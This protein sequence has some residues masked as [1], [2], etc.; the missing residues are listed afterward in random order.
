LE[1]APQETD[2]I[3]HYE[4][5]PGYG[6]DRLVLLVRD[7]QCVFAFWEVTDHGWA[8]AARRLPSTGETPRLTLRVHDLTSPAAAPGGEATGWGPGAWVDLVV[9]GADRWYLHLPQ[10]GRTVA[11]E[12]GAG[13]ATAFVPIARSPAVTTPPGTVAEW[14]EG[15]WITAAVACQFLAR[16]PGAT[17]P[18]RWSPQ[19]PPG[20]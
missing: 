5:P 10:P 6:V 13:T 11:A 1:S 16:G 4:V 2:A 9:A 14:A 12:I 17:S 8:A 20:V 3:P 15:D 19:A 7:P 18:G